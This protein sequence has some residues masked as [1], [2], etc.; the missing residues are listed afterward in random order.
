MVGR[1]K[2]L[3]IG[4]IRG[5]IGISFEEVKKDMSVEQIDKNKY[6]VNIFDETMIAF[7]TNDGRIVKIVGGG[8]HTNTPKLNTIIQD[9]IKEV[10]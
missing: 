1:H 6:Q 4:Y 8:H 2:L 7:T 3:L 9:I 10:F 5:I